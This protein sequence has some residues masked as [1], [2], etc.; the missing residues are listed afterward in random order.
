M[1]ELR[2]LTEADNAIV[3]EY[4]DKHY[5]ECTYI[6]D[7]F[8]KFGFSKD[9]MNK[10]CGNYYGYF[11]DHSMVGIFVFYNMGVMSCHYEDSGILSKLVLLHTIKKN[12]P[13]H[14]VGRR[15]YI[16]PIINT[17]NKVFRWD[18]LNICYFMLLDIDNFKEYSVNSKMLVNAVDSDFNGSVDFLIKMESDFRNKTKTINDFKNYIYDKDNH[19]EYIYISEG[20]KT[21]AQ[22]LI[23]MASKTIELI[24][25]VYTLNEYRNKGYAKT[26]VSELCSRV[27]SKCKQPGLIVNKSNTNAVNLYNSLGFKSAYEYVTVDIIT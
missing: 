11:V 5:S 10:K 1:E 25:G 27:L 14:I 16:A 24:E 22:G 21:V 7:C 23:R 9:Y 18:N 17:F 3:K 6:V 2:P 26:I 15:E 20:D 13:V 12:K 19:I 4:L 8:D